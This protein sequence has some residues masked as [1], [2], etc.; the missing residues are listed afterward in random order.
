MRKLSEYLGAMSM[1]AVGYFAMMRNDLR[2]PRIDK[3]PRHF[4]G[5]VDGLAFEDDQADSATGA[6]LVIGGMGV[7]RCAVEVAE[8][9]EMGLEN[10]AVAKLDLVDRKR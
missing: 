3:A 8:R 7:R 2:I 4:S 1:D 10:E 5:G 9:G 6:L